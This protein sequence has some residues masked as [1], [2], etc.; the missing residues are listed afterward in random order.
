[1]AH[2][3]AAL[4]LQHGFVVHAA[5]GM[6][7]ISTTGSTLAFRIERGSVKRLTLQPEDFGVSRADASQL[8]GGDANCNAAIAR[9]ILAGGEGAPRDIVIV[10]AAAALV[11]AGKAGDFREG[12]GLAEDSIDSGAARA[13]LEALSRFR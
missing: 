11:A 4:G 13:K 3:L 9:E 6:D 2:T 12:V 10:N 5:D 7:E 8:K 1:M